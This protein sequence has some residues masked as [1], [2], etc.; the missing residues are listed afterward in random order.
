MDG[1]ILHLEGAVDQGL[2]EIQHESLLAA[3]LCQKGRKQ[4]V[5]AQ[6]EMGVGELGVN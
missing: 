3:V 2:V 4:V 5:A 1:K 6:L